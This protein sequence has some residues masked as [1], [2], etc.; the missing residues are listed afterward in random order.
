MTNHLKEQLRQLEHAC[1]EQKHQIWHLLER[2]VM[3]LT[4]HRVPSYYDQ[5]TH[6][7]G[8]E[9]HSELDFYCQLHDRAHFLRMVYVRN[10]RDVNLLAMYEDGEQIGYTMM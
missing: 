5:Y 4:G 10:P 6:Y 3:S 1:A 2:D 8:G 7:P 9:W